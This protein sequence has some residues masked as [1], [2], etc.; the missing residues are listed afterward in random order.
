MYYKNIFYLYSTQYK[1]KTNFVYFHYIYSND[2]FFKFFKKQVKTEKNKK[3]DNESKNFE[4]EFKAKNWFDNDFFEKTSSEQFYQDIRYD[5]YRRHKYCYPYKHFTY[6]YKSPDEI[7]FTYFDSYNNKKYLEFH[8]FD[9]FIIFLKK[10]YYNQKTNLYNF[11]YFSI[12]FLLLPFRFIFYSLYINFFFKVFNLFFYEILE[13]F[14]KTD[15]EISKD[16]PSYFFIEE[17]NL[18]IIFYNFFSE[19]FEKPIEAF[20]LFYDVKFIKDTFF[21]KEFNLF[22]QLFIS[23]N[24]NNFFKLNYSLSYEYFFLLK[25][26]YSV[27][28]YNT[29]FFILKKF[30]KYTWS[31]EDTIFSEIPEPEYNFD[32][33]SHHKEYVIDEFFKRLKL[34]Y[35]KNKNINKNFNI[36]FL[37]KLNP[38]AI[39]FKINYFNLFTSLKNIKLFSLFFF[40]N[41][42]KNFYNFFFLKKNYL[43]F[44]TI[45]IKFSNINNINSVK[46]IF[47]NI[48]NI[49]YIFFFFEQNKNKNNKLVF[50]K[51]NIF[52]IELKQILYK[53]FFYKNYYYTTKIKFFLLN[54][55][56]FKKSVISVCI[57][58]LFFVF[59]FIFFNLSFLKNFS[60][61]LLIIIFVYYLFSTFN[62]FIKR[63]K[64]SKFTSALQRFWKRAYACFWLIEGFL[65]LIFTYY[66]LNASSE[67]IFIYDNY[68]NYLNDCFSLKSFIF[69]FF[70]LIFLLNIF[71]YL[72]LNI[73]YKSFYKISFDFNLILLIFFLL[74]LVESYQFYY[75][76][77]SYDEHFWYFDYDDLL[78]E[79]DF[80][81]PRM[82]NKNHYNSLILLAKFWHFIFIFVSWVFF[83]IKAYEQKKYK[84]FILA[85]NYQN[86][87][88]LLVLNCFCAV[89]YLKWIFRRFLD[90]TYYWFFT[91]FRA[92]NYNLFFFDIFF[93]FKSFLFN[94]FNLFNLFKDNLN[95]NFFSYIFVENFLF[96]KGFFFNKQI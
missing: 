20:S 53:Y 17:E 32:F 52:S 71:F 22:T 4:K 3:D 26:L 18:L 21:F 93:Y 69:N 86:I 36:N 70:L 92:N 90:Q 54:F 58:F 59:S 27:I 16:D 76:V 49:N 6:Y 61:W 67:P 19:I 40:F 51:K 79:I 82:R 75:L 43:E 77:N 94:L 45:F 50:F 57:G 48:K 84:F 33:P 39:L 41:F 28:H 47:K 13:I 14:F 60:Y 91:S 44:Y 30:N 38:F 95:F 62:F 25:E 63:Y 1:K 56:F 80:D 46:K 10:I 81:I 35:F 66:L 42:F 5:F 68:S 73:K 65:F 24:L 23:T 15:K 34:F 83:L 29:I 96:F 85:S 37:N 9:F 88:I 89:S 78:W 55:F 72:V 64:Y 8:S 11:F 87:L 7:Y 31:D 2:F 12:N 74:L